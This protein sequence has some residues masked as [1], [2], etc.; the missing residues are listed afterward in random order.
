MRICCY[1]LLGQQDSG[2]IIVFDKD[3]DKNSS[4]LVQNR[5]GLES[6]GF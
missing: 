2:M 5:K 1:F 4:D 6:N 3:F